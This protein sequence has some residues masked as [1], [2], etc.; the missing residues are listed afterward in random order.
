[1]NNIKTR[2]VR[3]ERRHAPEGGFVV[4]DCCD[5]NP[6]ERARRTAEGMARGHGGGGL[7]SWAR[8]YTSQED[9]RRAGIELAV[10]EARAEAEICQRSG[11]KPQVG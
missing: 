4:A 9:A 10:L 5:C 7:E 2:I 3:L 11:D 8:L 1:M 6:A